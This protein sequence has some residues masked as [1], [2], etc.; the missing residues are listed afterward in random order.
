MAFDNLENQ[1][2][3][4]A[5]AYTQKYKTKLISDDN[6]ATGSLVNSIKPKMLENGFSILAKQLYRTN[7]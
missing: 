3:K 6:K 1:L 4:Y 2:K 5:E 7:I